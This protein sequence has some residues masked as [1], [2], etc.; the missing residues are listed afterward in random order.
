MNNF[1]TVWYNLLVYFHIIYL[2]DIGIAQV[3]E[4]YLMKDMAQ[5]PTSHNL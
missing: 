2:L 4:I 3:I 1:E 5:G